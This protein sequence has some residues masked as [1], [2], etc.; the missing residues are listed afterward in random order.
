MLHA[1]SSILS[2]AGEPRPTENLNFDGTW[3][4]EL[5][6]TMRLSVSEDG[7]IRD[8]YRTAVGSPTAGEVFEL[9]GFATGDLISFTVNFGKYGTLTS[10]V[11]QHTNE[12]E[13]AIIKTMWLLAQN[14]PDLQEPS[15]LWGSVLTGYNNFTR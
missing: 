13:G 15:K 2:I 14:V 4:N 5:G 12:G 10:W 6:S 11:G 3:V 9:V 1:F 8:E 7:K